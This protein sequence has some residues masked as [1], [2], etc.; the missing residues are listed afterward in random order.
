[1]DA[2]RMLTGVTISGADDRVVY[3]DMVAISLAF[4]F[5]EWGIL[6]SN[7][8]QGTPRYPS[9]GWILN[10]PPGLRLSMHCCGEVARN[11]LAG[12]HSP[13]HNVRPKWTRRQFNGYTPPASE[14]FL[15]LAALWRGGIILQVP[16]PCPPASRRSRT[17]AAGARIRVGSKAC[18]ASAETFAFA[19]A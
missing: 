13:W 15:D 1:M 10:L 9:D 17:D 18:V 12:T 3:G 4:P 6:L 11:V 16:R 7:T 2:A 14:D 5:V 8:R 19:A